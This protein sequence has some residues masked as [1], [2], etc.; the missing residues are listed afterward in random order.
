MRSLLKRLRHNMMDSRALAKSLYEGKRFY[1]I[2][3]D[4]SLDER[5]DIYYAVDRTNVQEKFRRLL[6]GG[7]YRSKYKFLQVV[8]GTPVQAFEANEIVVVKNGKQVA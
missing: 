2:N 3:S 7:G 4:G 5:T 8:N 6:R 1:V